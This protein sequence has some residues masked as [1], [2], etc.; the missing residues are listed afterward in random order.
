MQHGS[1]EQQVSGLEAPAA[2]PRMDRQEQ[3]ELEAAFLAS[4]TEEEAE[5]EA[6]ISAANEERRRQALNALPFEQAPDAYWVE[7]AARKRQAR[8]QRREQRRYD[9][10]RAK[11]KNGLSPCWD[12]PTLRPSSDQGDLETA[13]ENVS[14]RPL[15]LSMRRQE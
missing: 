14:M 10:L 13:M 8:K 1:S 2:E 7:Y 9:S 4:L 5:E 3:A 11:A 12:P 6:A 15:R